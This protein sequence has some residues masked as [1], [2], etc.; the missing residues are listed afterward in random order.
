MS[1]YRDMIS[2][3]A[4]GP[5]AVATAV[6]KSMKFR[7]TKREFR[8]QSWNGTPNCKA[9]R[10]CLWLRESLL[11]QRPDTCQDTN[12]S[13]DGHGPAMQ[14]VTKD[15]SHDAGSGLPARKESG[16]QIK[17]FISSIVIFVSIFLRHLDQDIS[18]VQ[19]AMDKV[20]HQDHLQKCFDRCNPD[21]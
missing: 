8:S 15:H 5:L 9:A 1:T 12:K 17:G 19:V 7:L 10:T 18:R 4:R 14:P 3:P 2:T 20:V 13:D 11:D 21:L 6:N 16:V